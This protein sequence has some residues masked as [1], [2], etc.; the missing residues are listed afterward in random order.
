MARLIMRRLDALQAVGTKKY[1]L[2]AMSL[3]RIALGTIVLALYGLHWAQRGFLWGNTGAMPYGEF[4]TYLRFF[5]SFSLYGL[6]PSPLYATVLFWLGLAV[7][8]LFI[9]GFKTRLTSVLFYVFT[10]SL[11]QRNEFVMDGGDNLLIIVAF[12]MMFADCGAYFSVDRAMGRW[13]EKTN[14]FAALLHNYAVLAII[15]QICLLYFTSAFYKVQGHMW[16]D[17]T[18][19]YYV[20]RTN[21]FE[22][23]N[24][25]RLMW[26][27]AF[28][29]TFLTYS[30]FVFQMAFP[31]LAFNKKTK[32]LMVLGAWTFHLSIA[33]FMGL[34]WF[35]LAML[36]AEFV[37]FSDENYRRMGMWGAA[38]SDSI[39]DWLRQVGARPR[40][41]G[42]RV[43][44]LYDGACPLCRTAIGR[45][46][47]LDLFGLIHPVNF[48]DPAVML[49][50][51]VTFAA[52]ERRMHTQTTKGQVASGIRAVEAVA[53]RAP[54]LW[55][56]VPIVRLSIPLGIGD[57]VY[58]YIAAHRTSLFLPVGQCSSEA[59]SLEGQT[60]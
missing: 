2:I 3:L 32:W 58:D 21:E 14:P 16:Q 1:R 42:Y 4:I 40:V 7:T 39:Q 56:A 27:S 12:F 20:L 24:L 23:S 28:L 9:I 22:L 60:I 26:S 53:F 29:V 37:I 8:F 18:A 11:Y 17:G 13:T 10:W 54:L 6:S 57:R 45:L 25:G 33:Y 48:R 35:S 19:I 41:A 55:W 5:R 44:V 59:C 36:S 15:V 52:L 51:G 30:S 43:S 47:W 49:P 50:D 46:V 34:V 38:I 31:W